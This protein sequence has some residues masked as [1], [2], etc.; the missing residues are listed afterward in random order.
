MAKIDSTIATIAVAFVAAAAVSAMLTWQP[1]ARAPGETATS[2]T[3]PANQTGGVVRYQPEW[4]AS[5]TGRV[6]PKNGQIAISSAAAGEIVDVLV[7]ANAR[8]Q[9]GDLLVRLND[10][11][12][13]ARILAAEAET[14]V[15]RRERDDESKVEAKSLA[16]QR[17]KLADATEVADRDLHKAREALDKRLAELKE[18]GDTTDL[19]NL[20]QSVKEKEKAVTDAREALA[21][22]NKKDGMPLPDRLEAALTQS[23]SDLRLAYEALQRT[24]VRAP[25][26]GSV[27]RVDATLEMSHVA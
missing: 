22:I 17:R 3:Q 8:V 4:A 12:Q 18:G 11:D 7:S 20:R 9:A 2:G 13:L 10:T 25:S 6:E 5:A 1:N 15:R 16:E 23:R 14:D 24:R 21:E 27:L 26:A 19:V